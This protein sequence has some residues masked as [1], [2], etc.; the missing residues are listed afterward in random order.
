M[1]GMKTE[2]VKQA[3]VRF[4]ADSRMRPGDKLPSQN[5]LRLKLNVGSATISTA[6][7]ALAEDNVLE[8]R[9]K[10]GAF[11]K[12]TGLDGHTGRNIAILVNVANSIYNHIMVSQLQKYL[13]NENCH[14]IVLS[15]PADKD[16][17]KLKNYPGLFRNLRQKNISGIIVTCELLDSEF[18]FLDRE[19]MKF[20]SMLKAPKPYSS[21]YIDFAKYV[22]DAFKY[23]LAKGA[24]RPAIIS[25]GYKVNPV[26]TEPYINHLRELDSKLDYR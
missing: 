26:I 19:N 13:Q 25:R 11:I 6:I 24:R 1:A 3:L 9:D 22:D 15:C 20:I 8:I 18:E 23:L 17:K 16:S 14:N 7:N 12:K 2:M 21:C 10:V 5:N 4:I